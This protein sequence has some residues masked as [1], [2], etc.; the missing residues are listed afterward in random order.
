MRLPKQEKYWENPIILF[1]MKVLQKYCIFFHSLLKLFLEVSRKRVP[2]LSFFVD[3]K[4]WNWYN[5]K[6]YTAIYFLP[7]KKCVPRKKEN[8]KK[9]ATL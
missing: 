8:D 9:Q 4:L 2:K 7:K 6:V 1:P 3:C 5:L